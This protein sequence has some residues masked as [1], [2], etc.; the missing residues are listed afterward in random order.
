MSQSNV[1]SSFEALETVLREMLA[2]AHAQAWSAFE[3]LRH[4]YAHETARLKL[5][6]DEAPASDEES[7]CR[8]AL[9]E[10]ILMLD[11]QVRD[12]ATQR[13]AVLHAMLQSAGV[14]THR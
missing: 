1:V 11:A 13:I 7:A 12:L 9:L 6:D 14:A 8:L 4:R 3:T 2:A 10:R 5:H